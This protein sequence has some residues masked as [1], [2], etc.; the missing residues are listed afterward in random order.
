MSQ[1]MSYNWEKRSVTGPYKTSWWAACDPQHRCWR[2]LNQAAVFV[3][4][5]CQS[6]YNLR[7]F[8]L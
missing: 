6:N 7:S 5:L 8:S 1:V 2:L 3:S 4:I